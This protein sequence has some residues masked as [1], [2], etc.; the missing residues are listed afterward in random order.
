MP[1]FKIIQRG[2]SAYSYIQEYLPEYMF[3][4]NQKSVHKISDRYTSNNIIK[5]KTKHFRSL[6]KIQCKK[7]KCMAYT[8]LN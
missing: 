5:K 4:S 1:F 3:P 6:F 2:K 7:T 8:I